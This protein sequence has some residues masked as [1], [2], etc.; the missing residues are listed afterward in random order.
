MNRAMCTRRFFL[1]EGALVQPHPRVLQKLGAFGT[2]LAF[3]FVLVLA[4]KVNHCFNGFFLAFHPRVLHSHLSHR[5]H[6]WNGD[7]LALK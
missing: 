2:K 6:L 1:L 7:A 5:N 3:G 4:V